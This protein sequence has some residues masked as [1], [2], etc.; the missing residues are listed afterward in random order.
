MKRKKQK[1][2]LAAVAAAPDLP[3]PLEIE[4]APPAPESL[5]PVNA[6]PAFV[7]GAT[8]ALRSIEFWGRF[9]QRL[10]TYRRLHPQRYAHVVAFAENGSDSPS[11]EEMAKVLENAKELF[12]E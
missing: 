1:P 2:Q 8:Q 6:V 9:M 11:E 5:T 4:T 3:P 12:G 10:Q 7:A